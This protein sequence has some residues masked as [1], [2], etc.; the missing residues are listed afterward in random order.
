MRLLA[1]GVIGWLAWLAAPGC[2][3][4]YYKQQQDCVSNCAHACRETEDDYWYCPTAPA[5]AAVGR[6]S[7][8]VW[9]SMEACAA[10]CSCGS[11]CVK[12][13]GQWRCWCGGD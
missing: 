3:T 1:W 13:S 4:T 5:S 2:A 10:N 9:P 6:G 12:E 11:W 7:V 8:T